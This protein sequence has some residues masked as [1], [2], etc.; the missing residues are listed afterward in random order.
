M[1]S[2]LKLIFKVEVYLYIK[3]ASVY[4]MFPLIKW[5]TALIFELTTIILELEAQRDV[6]SF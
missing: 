4:E 3:L 6:S 2:A 1:H 5:S